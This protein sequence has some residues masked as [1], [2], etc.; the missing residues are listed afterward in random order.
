MSAGHF[1]QSVKVSPAF[2]TRVLSLP[3][4]QP[5]IARQKRLI[6]GYDVPYLAGYSKD[7]NRLYIDRRLPRFIFLG[8]HKIDLWALDGP[9]LVHEQTE[10]ALID[11]AGLDYQ[12]AH[13]VA[14]ICE[15]GILHKRRINPQSYEDK[16]RPYIRKAEG[17]TVT[18]PPLDL[19]V[20]P[21]LD[22]RDRSELRKL[23]GAK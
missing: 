5:E 1:H 20:T 16:L 21:Y 23:R 7:G 19:D 2:V 22:E 18:N 10:K 11:H 9:L 12:H 8:R 14:T 15:H 6:H 3:G 4:V 17:E 13:A